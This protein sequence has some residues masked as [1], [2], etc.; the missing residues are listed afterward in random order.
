MTHYTL[1]HQVELDLKRHEGLVLEP[2]R[3]SVGKLTIGYGRNL[4]DV[5]ISQQEA[6][7]MLMHDMTRTLNEMN[8]ALPQWIS[9]PYQVRRAL[10][11]M[12]FQM[13]VRG[14]L[15]FKRMLAA[16]EAGAWKR[17]AEEALNSEWAL[18]TPQRAREVAG[19]IAEADS[20]VGIDPVTD[21][22]SNYN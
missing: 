18:Q 1:T 19:W 7:T 21:D 16:L 2:Y 15:K 10:V 5:G 22:Y 13:G 6:E 9:W 20:R 8:R 4:D 12:C 17:A 11:N 3:D 14:V